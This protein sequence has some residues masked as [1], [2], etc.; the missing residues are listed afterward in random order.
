[1]KNYWRFF[2]SPRRHALSLGFG[3]LLFCGCPPILK[4]QPSNSSA[5][6]PTPSVSKRASRA[7]LPPFPPVQQILD[8]FRR[9]L[10]MSPQAR[11]QELAHKPPRVRKL[12]LV[13]LKEYDALSPKARKC[14]LQMIELRAY[15]LPLMK[16]IPSA[17]HQWIAQIPKRDRGLIQRRLKQW[18]QL[19]PSLQHEVL[20]NEMILHYFVRLHT[21]P[22]EQRAHFLE[23]YPAGYRKVLEERLKTWRAL[24]LA[25]RRRMYHNFRRFFAL[26]PQEQ[27]RTLDVLP[28]TERARL[29]KTI[30]ALKALSADQRRRCIDS[31]HKFVNMTPEQRRL[32]LVNAKRWEEMTPAQR[33]AWRALVHHLPPLP[34]GFEK[35]PLPPVLPPLPPKS[36]HHHGESGQN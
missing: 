5:A 24:P 32:F 36:A 9:L 15:L 17:R 21:V 26:P 19:A 1:M 33:Q 18:D 16:M 23:Q 12:L 2:N 10:A 7:A 30:N 6:A 27:N 20:E 28:E 11:D 22:E 34:P 3:I 13:K 8:R 29:E 25:D 4:A 35:P 31:I 14:R